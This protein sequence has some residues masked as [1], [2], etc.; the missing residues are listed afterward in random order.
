MQDS[1]RRKDMPNP[2][3]GFHHVTAIASDPQRILDFYTQ[4][5]GFR[6][7]KQTVNFDDPGSY[8]FYLGDNVGFRSRSGDFSAR[9]YLTAPKSKA[10]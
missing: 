10:S 6:F 4:V 9:S 2:I 7:V 3:V 5:L 1:G 8:H